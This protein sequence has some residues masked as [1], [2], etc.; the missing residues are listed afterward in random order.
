MLC[1][2]RPAAGLGCGFRFELRDLIFDFFRYLGQS[3]R[4]IRRRKLDSVIFRRIVR[5]GEIDGAIG[6][7]THD[8]MRN[9]RRGR[10]LGDQQ[11]LDAMCGQYPGS[12]RRQIFPQKTRIAAHQ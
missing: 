3:R 12:H 8:G 2:V 4:A 11:C 7:Q 1:L 6:F 5:S 10:R 9:G